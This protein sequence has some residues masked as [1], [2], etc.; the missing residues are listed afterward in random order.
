MA[1]FLIRRALQGMLVI[2]GVTLVVFVA[3]RMVGDPVQMMLPLS[4]SAEQRAAFSQQLG[5]DQPLGTQFLAFVGDLLRFDFGDS[6]WQRRP[7]IEIVLTK[8]PRTLELIAAGFGFAVILGVPLGALAAMRPDGLWD[9][10]IVSLSLIGLSVP[11]FWLGLILVMVFAV[12]LGLFPTSGSGS[13]SHLV[14]PALTL[15]IPSMARIMM[16]TRSSVIAELN[17]Q[18]V[19]TARARGL[20][21][22]HILFGHAMR[23]ALVPV[24]TLAGWEVISA[25]AG[26]TVVVETVFAW[27]GLGMTAMGAINHSDM[28][29]LQ[30][31]VF[32]VALGIVLVSLLLDLL[33]KLIDPRIDLA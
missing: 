29:L 13:L 5:L 26:Y 20:P 1:Q 14:L 7:A 25:W 3:T 11:Q 19:R 21:F 10:I 12:G 24:L 16:L 23:N 22:A 31:I 2:L 6:L 33:Y 4:A 18:Y 15:G 8:L 27:P 17:Q 9:R 30:A 32:V 28:F